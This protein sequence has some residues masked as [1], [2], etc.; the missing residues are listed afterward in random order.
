MR[1][2]AGN[3]ANGTMQIQEAEAKAALARLGRL[4]YI[5][6]CF[7]CLPSSSGGG[8]TLA[9]NPDN[10]GCCD[11]KGDCLDSLNCACVKKNGQ[12]SPYDRE[13]S[14]ELKDKG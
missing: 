6:E 7:D 12:M 11:C 14:L 5:A 2:P 8:S 1:A 9:S 13:G 3:G 10:L 4:V